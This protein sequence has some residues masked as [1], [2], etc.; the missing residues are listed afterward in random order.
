M[1]SLQ[2]KCLLIL[3]QK[4]IGT[5]DNY[6]VNVQLPVKSKDELISICEYFSMRNFISK[7]DIRGWN[8]IACQVEEKALKYA[9]DFYTEN[10]NPQFVLDTEK[11]ERR[12]C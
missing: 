10:Q 8:Y 5:S 7:V 1:T 3:I 11:K 2:E 9:I 4:T 6:L 12:L